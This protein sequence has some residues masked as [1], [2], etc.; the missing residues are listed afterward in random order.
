MRET[1][2]ERILV[3][4]NFGA[5][6]AAAALPSDSTEGRLLLSSLSDRVDDPVAGT[7]D[8]RG[9]EGVVVECA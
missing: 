4:L 2:S 9:H 8:L 7:I 5:Q 1:D 6:P 3:A